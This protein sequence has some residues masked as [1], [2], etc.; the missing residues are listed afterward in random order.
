MEI[1]DCTLKICGS[2]G[3]IGAFIISLYVLLAKSYFTEKGKNL[4]TKEDIAEI[5]KEVEK[6]KNELQYKTQFKSKL[7]E[8]TKLAAIQAFECLDTLHA[9]VT[10]PHYHYKIDT[11][12]FKEIEN[13]VRQAG[14]NYNKAFAKFNLYMANG[15]IIDS[16]NDSSRIISEMQ[17]AFVDANFTKSQFIETVRNIETTDLLEFSIEKR[18]EFQKVADRTIEAGNKRVIDANQSVGKVLTENKEKW[19]NSREILRF[20]ISKFISG[21]N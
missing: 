7:H 2:I 19:K 8:E 3:A 5:T 13:A 12:A 1:L 15:E 18:V 9:T 21:E 14:D 11:K 6:V 16:F 10:F 4:A 20:S 17:P